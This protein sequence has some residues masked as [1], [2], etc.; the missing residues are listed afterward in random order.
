[1]LEAALEYNKRNLSVI[2]VGQDKVPLISWREY[3]ERIASQEEIKE[4]WKKY[5][6]ANVGIVTGEISNLTVLDCDSQI[7]HELVQQIYKGKTPLVKT[8]RGYHYYFQ[9]AKDTRNT[10]RIQ[11]MDL[12]LRSSGGYVVAPPSINGSGNAYRFINDLNIALDSFNN[13]FLSSVYIGNVRNLHNKS[14]QSLQILTQ[15]TRDEDLFRTAN[16]L[17]KGGAN[18]DFVRQV[19]EILARNSQPPFPEKE[20]DAKIKSAISRSERRERNL[21]QEI[22]E[23]ISLQDSYFLLTDIYNSLH[24]LTREEKNNVNIIIHRLYKEEKVIEKHGDR[25]GCYRPVINEYEVLDIMNAPENEFKIN[26]P[27]GIHQHCRIYPK[28]VIVISGVANMGKSAMAFEICR[29]NRHLFKNK[30]VRFQTT[31]AG[32]TEIKRRLLMYPQENFRHPLKWW[33]DNVEFI[34]KA[35]NWSDIVDPDGF[36]IVDYISDYAEAYKIPLYIQQIHNK[37][38]EGIAVLV[39]QKDPNKPHGQGGQATRHAARLAIDIER[40]K[41]TL[42]KVKS[43][44]RSSSHGYAHPD[45]AY[46]NFTLENGWEFKPNGEWIFPDFEKFKGV[47]DDE[48]GYL[49]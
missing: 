11:N 45:G 7:A 15:G 3:Q 18:P 10:V 22:K 6:K 25:R 5:P 26:F 1:M 37:L 31:E 20:I 19:L 14:L 30:K 21:A 23:W 24:I 32:D 9:F 49:H 13:C 41:V 35:D 12:D 28:N 4:W 17:I 46:K 44:I 16:C 33:V 43:P 2:P 40:N 47:I 39:I 8:P 36:N 38:R 42:V 34:P 48:G 29:H 27:L